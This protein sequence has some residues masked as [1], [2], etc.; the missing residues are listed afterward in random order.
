MLSPD[1]SEPRA[2]EARRP[3]R[4]ARGR[5]FGS[6]TAA[7]PAGAPWG[8]VRAFDPNEPWDARTAE[9]LTRLY[10]SEEGDLSRPAPRD[11]ARHVRVQAA[12]TAGEA[13]PTREPVMEPVDREWSFNGVAVCDGLDPVGNVIQFREQTG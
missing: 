7:A 13:E 6:G 11:A 9:A 12:G 2:G 4:R 8:P 3:R 1:C 5:A 10:E